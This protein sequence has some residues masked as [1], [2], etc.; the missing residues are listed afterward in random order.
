MCGSVKLL[1]NLPG[2]LF[3][4]YNHFSLLSIL[5]GVAKRMAAMALKNSSE[6]QCIPIASRLNAFQR[7]V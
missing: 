7:N 4:T 1:K 5:C 3:H 2:L 6:L